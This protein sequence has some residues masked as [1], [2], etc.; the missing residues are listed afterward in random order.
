[1]RGAAMAEYHDV[2]RELGSLLAHVETLNREMKEL[3]TDVREL[4]DDFN[5]VKGGSRVLIGLAAILGGGM[6][7]ALNHFFGKA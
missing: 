2:N 5:A 4:R 3:K 6:T 1:M 7:W